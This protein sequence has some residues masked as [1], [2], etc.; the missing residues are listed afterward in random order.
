MRLCRRILGTTRNGNYGLA[1][2]STPSLR[3]DTKLSLA[4]FKVQTLS[5]RRQ[6]HHV[7]RVDALSSQ[8]G[9]GGLLRSACVRWR[10]QGTVWR[11]EQE[12]GPR[13]GQAPAFAGFRF[14][15]GGLG[16]LGFASPS[17]RGFLPGLGVASIRRS[18]A[19][20]RSASS[21]SLAIL[22]SVIVRSE[23]PFCLKVIRV[24]GVMEERREIQPVAG[25]G[26]PASEQ[27]HEPWAEDL[28]RVDPL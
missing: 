9:V 1:S 11:S 26:S 20:R 13:R 6:T 27:R 28:P 24:P 25:K 4:L 18:T 17:S 12:A 23:Q 21:T 10:K 3:T 5:P 15:A 22:P 19:S 16:A 2:R 14:P 8:S 7:S